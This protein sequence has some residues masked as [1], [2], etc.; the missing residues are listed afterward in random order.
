MKKK[1]NK[2]RSSK[3]RDSE[4]LESS[5]ATT[6]KVKRKSRLGRW[7]SKSSIKPDTSESEGERKKKKSFSFTKKRR[8]SSADENGERKRKSSLF[9]RSK[10][11]SAPPPEP[12]PAPVVEPEPAEF[13]VWPNIQTRLGEVD[14]PS[15]SI[16][17]SSE[18]HRN[19]VQDPKSRI[20]PHLAQREP[21]PE[22]ERL[23]Q[24]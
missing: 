11:K 5:P 20:P 19:L 2:R 13:G 1:K 22:P 6:P 17:N 18:D 15:L 8:D 16:P 4:D 21:E 7:G 24:K 9:G 23:F 12:E 14:D 3:R 10:K